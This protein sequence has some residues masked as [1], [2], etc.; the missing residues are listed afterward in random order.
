MGK[1][2]RI[3]RWVSVPCPDCFGT[4]LETGGK[5]GTCKGT[6]EVERVVNEIVSDEEIKTN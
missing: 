3:Q 5:C 6:R 4:G 1:H 2:K